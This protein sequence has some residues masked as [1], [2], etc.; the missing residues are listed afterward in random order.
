MK[1]ASAELGGGE[2]ARLCV[3]TAQFGFQYG[4]ANQTGALSDSECRAVLTKASEAGI[5]T[6]DTATAYG[7]SEKRL[8]QFGMTGWRVITKLPPLPMDTAHVAHWL[9]Q[10][11]KESFDRLE[12]RSLYGLLLHRPEDLIGNHGPALYDA[13]LEMKA[14]G[15]VERIGASVYSPFQLAAVWP[16]YAM[17]LIQGP[18][19]VLDRRMKTSGAFEELASHGVEIH[20]RSAFLQGLLLMERWPVKFA[21]WNHIEERWRSWLARTGTDAL[22]ACVGFVLSEALVSRVVVGVDSVAHLEQIVACAN[23]GPMSCPAE[24]ALEDDAILNPSRWSEL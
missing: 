7:E 1:V 9:R 21:R 13:L 18:F 23:G 15:K 8:G 10:A 11:T 24:L 20:V 16:K 17:D 14:E 12:V 2:A 19:N 6:I 3:G 5:D 22:T 4:I